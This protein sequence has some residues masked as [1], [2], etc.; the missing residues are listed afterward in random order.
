MIR[1]QLKIQDQQKALRIERLRYK[2]QLEKNQLYAENVLKLPLITL[3]TTLTLE[4]LF[5]R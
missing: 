4:F 2:E 3:Y 5:F 1:E